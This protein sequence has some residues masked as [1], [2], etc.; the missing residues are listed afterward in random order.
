MVHNTTVFQYWSCEKKHNTIQ[1]LEVL[2]S[3]TLE[4]SLEVSQVMS[5]KMPSKP[6]KTAIRNFV[7][8][9][10]CYHFLRGK[11]MC[12]GGMP[13][14]SETTQSLVNSLILIQVW[15]F[16]I[17]PLSES[18]DD[19]IELLL[20]FYVSLTMCWHSSHIEILESLSTDVFEP[21]TSTRS[22]NFSS[23][24]HITSFSLKMSS[25]KC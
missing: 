22:R 13:V 15:L 18:T 8:Y 11:I 24:M 25:S 21:Q 19:F 20:M 7:C 17:L 23:L 12:S 2:G 5:Q 4:I 9:N 10:A 6:D 14:H 1:R 3:I 16:N